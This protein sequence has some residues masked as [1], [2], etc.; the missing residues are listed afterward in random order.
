MAFAAW[1]CCLT[2]LS[3]GNLNDEGT[4]NDQDQDSFEAELALIVFPSYLEVAW[5][6]QDR[7]GL[8]PAGSHGV[9][10][11]VSL[12]LAFPFEPFLGSEWFI[13]S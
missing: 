7:Y 10:G 3:F 6:L 5:G 1:L 4:S 8:E 9:W 12:F 2:R 13:I 11:L